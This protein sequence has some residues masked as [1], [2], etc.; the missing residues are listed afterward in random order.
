[1][2]L[3]MDFHIVV[4]HEKKEISAKEF[5]NGT[6]N[7]YSL[8]SIYDKPNQDGLCLI[9]YNDILKVILVADGMG[10][11]SGANKVAQVIFDS[12]KKLFSKDKDE[13]HKDLRSLI[14]DSFELA[15]KNVKDLKIGAGSTLTA[16]EIQE[17]YARFYNCGDSSSYLF[18]ARGKMKFKTLEHSPLGFGK[19]SGLIEDSD[20]EDNIPVEGNIVSNGI[21]FHDMWVEVSA[22]VEHTQNDIFLSSSDGMTKNYKLDDLIE[23]V[24]GG[25]FEER[26]KK[27][28]ETALN[29]QE[30]F[31]SDDNT[32]VVFKRN[33]AK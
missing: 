32:V 14:L 23:I 9:S 10:G 26:T 20:N 15:D 12:F 2:E 6:I 19:E 7:F 1:M 17:D 4:N 24:T 31:L 11:H 16:I 8:K 27:L 3:R 29:N 13:S 5:K 21:G 22:I 33:S 18:G 30:R 28:F 25:Q